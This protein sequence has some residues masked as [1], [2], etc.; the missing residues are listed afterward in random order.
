MRAKIAT[1]RI[2]IGIVSQIAAEPATSRVN[3]MASVA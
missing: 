3:M 2:E 1:M